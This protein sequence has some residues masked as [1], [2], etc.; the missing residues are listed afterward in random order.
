MTKTITGIIIGLLFSG[1]LILAIHFD[2]N[3]LQIAIAF[4]LFIFPSI[5]IS[6][7]KSRRASLILTIVVVVFAYI[8]YKYDF[9][10][11]WVGV[12]MALIIGLPTYFYKIHR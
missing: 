9:T 1:L 4:L 8:S 12:L 3:V 6:S 2:L 5:F 10:D 11:V 7:F